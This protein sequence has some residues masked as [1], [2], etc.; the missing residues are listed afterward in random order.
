MNKYIAHKI[1]LAISGI[2]AP[3]VMASAAWAGGVPAPL[4]G[5]FGPAGLLVAGVAYGGYRLAKH[6]RDRS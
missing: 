1:V 5:A 4:A 6:M 2:V 3:L